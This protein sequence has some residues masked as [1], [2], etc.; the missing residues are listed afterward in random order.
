MPRPEAPVPKRYK[1]HV[2]LVLPA[3]KGRPRLAK[4]TVDDA[5]EDCGKAFWVDRN[6]TP[7]W[8]SPRMAVEFWLIP[9]GPDPRPRSK[10]RRKRIAI[11]L[12]PQ[13]A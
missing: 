1:G 9:I 6:N 3:R 2:L 8:L 10:K 7:Q 11:N 4:V 13:T 12:A 5:G